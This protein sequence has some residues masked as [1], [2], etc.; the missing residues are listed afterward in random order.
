MLRKTVGGNI[1]RLTWPVEYDYSV[2][3]GQESEVVGA[4]RAPK[5]PGGC[6]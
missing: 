3:D 5:D 1:D 6:C 4:N 2:E